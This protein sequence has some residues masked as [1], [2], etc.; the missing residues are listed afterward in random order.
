MMQFVIFNFTTVMIQSKQA[1]E[2]DK[3]SVAPPTGEA[4]YMKW[5]ELQMGRTGSKKRT[6]SE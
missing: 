6:S 2:C 4:C 1:I 5:S 3:S